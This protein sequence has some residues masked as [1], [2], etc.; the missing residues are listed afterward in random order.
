V[1][2]ENHSPQYYRKVVALSNKGHV[3]WKI[4]TADDYSFTSGSHVVLITTVEFS[5]IACEY[6][7]VFVE[8]SGEFKPVAVLGLK[9]NQNSFLREDNSWNGKYIPAYIRRYPFILSGDMSATNGQDITYTVCIDESYIGFNKEFGENLFDSD[10]RYSTY[11]EGTIKFLKDFQFEGQV[12]EKFC[13]KLTKLNIL[14]P[15]QANIASKEQKDFS[16]SGF[17][18]VS[19]D[20]LKGKKPL[21]LVEL[22]KSDEMAFIYAHLASLSKFQSLVSQ[23]N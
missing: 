15:M 19:N 20:K 6:P 1:V 9:P 21:E 12:T 3:D 13:K 10:G 8:T 22:V 5:F 7:I 18:I 11:L 4:K 14:E 23:I 17:W 16:L 2:S